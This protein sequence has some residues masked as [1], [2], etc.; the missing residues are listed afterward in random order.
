M[1]A[2]LAR[3]SQASVKPLDERLRRA[4]QAWPMVRYRWW[5]ILAWVVM[6]GALTPP[7]VHVERVLE[8]RAHV[9]GSESEA[10]ERDLAARF[11]SP[12]AQF[13]VLVISGAPAADSARRQL[14]DSIVRRVSSVPGVTRVRGWRSADDTLF[15]ADSGRVTLVLAGIDARY[16]PGD[17]ITGLRTATRRF[18]GPSLRW[19]G[20]AALNAD[21][22]QV[23]AR[24]AR[25]AERHV[26]PLA[27]VLLIVAFGTLVAAVLPLVT[28]ALTILAAL[29]AAALIA[30]RWPLSIVL[31]TFV[32]MIGLGLGIDYALLVVSRFRE[33]LAAGGTPEEA[34]AVA[35]RRAGHT[36]LLSGVSVGIGFCGLM[37]AP[38]SD[39]RSLAVGGVLVVATAVAVATTLLP[40]LLAQLGARVNAGRLWSRGALMGNERAWRTWGD[41]VVRRPG[42]VLLL[43][44][45]PVIALAWPARRMA[46]GTPQGTDWMPPTLE[47]VV[48]WHEM[49]RIKRGSVLQTIRVVLDL[50]S[51]Q[52]LGT[53]AGW[54][55]LRRVRARFLDD[56]RVALVLA[57]TSRLTF[58]TLA[59][60]VRRMSV[61]PDRRAVLLEVVPQP[62]VGAEQAIELARALR[63]LDIPAV[64]GVPGS[65]I[66]VGG[67]PALRADYLDTVM[68][69]FP[70][71][72][73]LIV[74]A[75]LLAL[76]VGFRS[77]LI[78]VKAVA[79]NLLSV[80]AG[81]G[82]LVLVFQDGHGAQ[83]LGVTRLDQVFATV[84]T[85]VFCTVFGLSMDYE[86]FL[87]ARVA[88]ERRRGLP[89]RAAI[90]AGL[91]STGRVI[92]SAAL[93]MA[94]VFGS[95]IAADFVLIKMLGLAL[96]VAVVVDATLVRVA[97]GPALL[98]L[99]GRWNWYPGQRAGL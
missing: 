19:T 79:L 85:L 50:P 78:P 39:L 10:V 36:I 33:A 71:A 64:T 44:S 59:D 37:A 34:A 18:T 48:G 45:V 81:F 4:D 21:M 24:D 84:P 89:E 29:G 58:A 41:W 25:A 70:L 30:A 90:A 16:A 47:A 23:S 91:A 83:L 6:T 88:E 92:T 22:R 73:L 28:G 93:I 95:F 9:P 40:A 99:A 20:E 27:A 98:A 67:L 49:E 68:R 63:R 7:A 82:A 94:A 72:V 54:M 80:A 32:T 38:V 65:R 76:G 56:S 52:S 8:A 61:T 11:A 46:A 62:D 97:I 17:V 5:V 2:I 77:I 60:S 53:A 55:A 15:V 87:V 96:T 43:G 1:A 13:A 86:V 57:P 12:Y 69:R 31:Q 51:D 26:M 14:V 75:T 3:A 42:M 74:G 35:A 66:R